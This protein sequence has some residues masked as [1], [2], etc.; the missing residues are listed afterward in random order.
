MDAAHVEELRR[1][2]ARTREE[3]FKKVSRECVKSTL[4]NRKS[5][6]WQ[7]QARAS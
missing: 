4:V 1:C 2:T 5:I 6:L 3:V 7:L